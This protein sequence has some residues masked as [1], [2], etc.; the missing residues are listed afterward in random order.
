MFSRLRRRRCSRNRTNIRRCRG[1]TELRQAVADHYARHQGLNLG[2]EEVIVTSGATEAL[3]AAILALVEPG[4]EVICFQPL[5]DAY[6]PLI[7]RGG[8]VAR[9]V[10]LQPPHW[11]VDKAALEAAITPRTRAL[12]LCKPAQ[13]HRDHDQ[14]RRAGGD[15]RILRRA[16]PDRYLRR[17]VGARHLRRRASFAR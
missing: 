8:G 12:I 16:R 7:E 4:D 9:F 6:V 13:P 17:S 5:Y 15:R 11:R 10:Q 3:A 1:L 2:F 14:R